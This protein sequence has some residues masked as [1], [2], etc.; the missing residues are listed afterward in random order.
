MAKRNPADVAAELQA[1]IDFN[2][3]RQQFS[4]EQLRNRQIHQMQLQANK[5]MKLAQIESMRTNMRETQEEMG[6]KDLD[7]TY[8]ESRTKE[9]KDN[10]GEYRVVIEREA[11]VRTRPPD[12]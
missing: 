4:G 6:E 10:I 7:M 12:M 3:V 2:A 9:V 11:T 8:L 1:V 5:A